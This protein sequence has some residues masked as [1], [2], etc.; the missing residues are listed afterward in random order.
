MTALAW[1]L[2][3]NHIRRES[4][5]NAFGMVRNGGRKAHQGWDLLARPLTDCFAIADGRIVDAPASKSYGKYVILQFEYRSQ[6]LYAFYC[7]LGFRVC[8]KGQQVTRGEVVGLTG[9]TGNASS[10]RGDD[11]HLHFEIRTSALGHPVGLAGRIDPAR[12]YGRAPVGWTFY[13]LRGGKVASYGLPGLKVKGL[14][15]REGLE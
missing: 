8:S 1:P 15:V 14:N 12:L 3:A 11:Q 10:M 4:A 9:N 5:H 13:D 7:H 6:T 2:E